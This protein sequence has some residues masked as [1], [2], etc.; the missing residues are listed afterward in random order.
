MPITT[1]LITTLLFVQPVRMR[2]Y[3]EEYGLLGAILIAGVGAIMVVALFLIGPI[4]KWANVRP[5]PI[6]ET[7]ACLACG[8]TEDRRET[9]PGR[10]QCLCGYEG[11]FSP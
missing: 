11:T 8:S 1:N 9:G 2:L 5:E 7:V 6:D 3:E 10:Y 4:R